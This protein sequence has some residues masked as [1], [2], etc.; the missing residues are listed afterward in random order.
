VL[1]LPVARGLAASGEALA[2]LTGITPLVSRGQL[3]FLLWNA[4]PDSTRAQQ[5]LGWEPTPLE[6]GLRATLAGLGLV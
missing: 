5:E 6:D 3:Y 2:R 1:P 4:A